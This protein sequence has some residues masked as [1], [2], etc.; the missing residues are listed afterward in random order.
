MTDNNVKVGSVKLTFDNVFDFLEALSETAD[1][2]NSEYNNNNYY[3]IIYTGCPVI[4]GKWTH[5]VIVRIILSR[6]S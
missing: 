6:K 2:D 4:G 1:G 3:T 5:S